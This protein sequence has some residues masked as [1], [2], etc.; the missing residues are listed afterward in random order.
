MFPWLCWIII[1]IIIIIIIVVVVVVV[2]LLV[3]IIIIIII[4]IAVSEVHPRHSQAFRFRWMRVIASP[5]WATC[6]GASLLFSPAKKLGPNVG[7]FGECLSFGLVNHPPTYTPGKWVEYG[8]IRCNKTYWE[9]TM[10]LVGQLM[11]LLVVWGHVVF[12]IPIGVPRL[13]S[14][15]LWEEDSR[16]PKELANCWKDICWLFLLSP[17]NQIVNSSVISDSRFESR[18]YKQKISNIHIH[19]M[20]TT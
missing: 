2:V 16:I 17:S 5:R 10:V 12:R 3:I 13:E 1:I 14:Q 19:N 11:V 4:P 6:R 20:N 18:I 9:K 8:V 7:S 15:F